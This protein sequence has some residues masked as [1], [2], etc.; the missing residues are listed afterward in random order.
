MTRQCG[1]CTLCCRLLPVKSLAK[2]ANTRCQH[3]RTGK[4]CRVYPKLLQTSPECA[5]WNC[6]WLVE[7]AGET[8]RPDRAHY[9]IDIMPDFIRAADHEGA[10]PINIAVVQVW[11][12]PSYPDAHRDP[13]LRDWLEQTKQI[14][15]V[16]FNAGDAIVIFPPSRMD[17]HE[18][19]ERTSLLK[20][21]GHTVRQI[22]DG[23]A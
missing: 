19:L 14:A 23:L 18:W 2:G 17:N 8:R 10:E 9:V 22:I 7:D 16:R 4:G 13:A 5:I 3:Q 1:G 15:I 21:P 12:D 6:R 20:E 11:V